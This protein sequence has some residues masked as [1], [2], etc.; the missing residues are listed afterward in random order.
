MC[1]R[2]WHRWRTDGSIFSV[3]RCTPGG[4]RLQLWTNIGS[5]NHCPFLLCFLTLSFHCLLLPG[6]V[7]LSAAFLH[8]PVCLFA[9]LSVC[10]STGLLVCLPGCLPVA[11]SFIWR[12]RSSKKLPGVCA[13]A[14]KR[15]HRGSILQH[16]HSSNIL[17][18]ETTGRHVGSPPKVQTA[19]P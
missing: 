4:A 18:K 16:E 1:A 5:S 15:E 8:R 12:L 9:C 17:G 11:R 19:V 10:L 2:P 3:I 14:H 7:C 6:S 13:R